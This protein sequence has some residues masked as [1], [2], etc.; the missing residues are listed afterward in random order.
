MKVF[1]PVEFRGIRCFVRV[2]DGKGLNQL[3]CPG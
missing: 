1:F 2:Q 3:G